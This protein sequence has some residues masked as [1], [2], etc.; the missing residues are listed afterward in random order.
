MHVIVVTGLGVFVVLDLA[1]S[2]VVRALVTASHREPSSVS[3]E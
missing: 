3:T 1:R 2:Q